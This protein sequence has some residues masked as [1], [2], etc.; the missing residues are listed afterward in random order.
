MPESYEINS[1]IFGYDTMDQ[2]FSEADIKN[3]PMLFN[4][5]EEAAEKLGGP[6]T[7]AFLAQL[8]KN[9]GDP[10]ILDTRVHMLMPG[11]FPCIPGFHHDDV[12]RTRGDGQ[13]DYD[14]PPYHVQH[15]LLL[16]NGQ[17][18]P[19][20]FAL[21]KVTL[22]YVKKE[23]GPVYKVWHKETERAI[24]D[25]RLTSLMAPSNTIIYFD[26]HTLHQGTRAISNGWRFF[27]RASWKTGRIPTNEV[28]RQVQVYLEKPMEGW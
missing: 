21:G 28:R 9:V 16:L 2:G 22:P 23:D 26:A 27:A 24:G 17:I 12:P 14:N 4:C 15:A 11:W 8:K 10:I 20:E 13:P 25:G 3:E 7:K 19:T 1:R 6:I 5:D 18:C